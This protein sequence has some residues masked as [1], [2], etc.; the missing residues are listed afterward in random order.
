MDTCEPIRISCPKCGSRYR[1]KG[2]DIFNLRSTSCGRC[3]EVLNVAPNHLR[4]QPVR[5]DDILGWLRL[6]DQED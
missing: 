4:P 2:E 6:A 5:E 1:I 3:K